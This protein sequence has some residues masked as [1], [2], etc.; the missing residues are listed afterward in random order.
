ML[1]RFLL[2]SE[3]LVTVQRQD[4]DLLKIIQK[5]HVERDE[6]CHPYCLS[7][8]VLYCRAR[9]VGKPK[10]VVPTAAVPTIFSYFHDSLWAYILGL[11]RPSVNI[12]WKGIG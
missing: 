3:E 7:K 1:T 9:A 6:K 10:V 12:I 4:P 2:A 8:G 11:L 5:I